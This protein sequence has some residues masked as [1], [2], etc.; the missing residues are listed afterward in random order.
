MEMASTVIPLNGGTAPV[1]YT[2]ADDQALK[3]LALEIAGHMPDDEGDALRVLEH[4]KTLV[5]S[6]LAA[7]GP[8]PII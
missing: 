2:P 8:T 6:F 5:N 1:I 7:R 4:V 3:R